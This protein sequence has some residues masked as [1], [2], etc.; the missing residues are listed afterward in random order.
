M[1]ARKTNNYFSSV[2][3]PDFQARHQHGGCTGGPGA[4][5]SGLAGSGWL[6]SEETEE[7][8]SRDKSAGVHEG[9]V[10]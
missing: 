5:L 8:I 10:R 7:E 3:I 2:I 1:Q 9:K 4:G 6:R